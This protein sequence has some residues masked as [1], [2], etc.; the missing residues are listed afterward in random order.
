MTV[1]SSRR[2]MPLTPA[3][4]ER[5][6]P[7]AS[8]RNTR[9]TWQRRRQLPLLAVGVVLVA[10][11]ALLFALV[12]NRGPAGT[13]VLVASR[14]LPAGHVLSAADLSTASLRGPGVASI[15]AAGEA[16]LL[17]RPLVMPVAAG[18]L[19]LPADVG[20][21]NG[22][23]AG[24]AVVALALKPGQYPPMVGAGDRVQILNTAT[25]AAS[26][27]NG[28][29][30][31]GGPVGQTV[32]AIVLA[33]DPQPEG[34]AVAVV[35]SVQVAAGQAPAVAAMGAAGTGSLVLLAPEA[36]GP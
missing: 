25:A 10:G 29:A 16:G 13:Q 27:P 36:S 28:A 32:P 26:G 20:S 1:T 21:A 33:V 31:A 2:S 15:P 35:A 30:A 23:A 24:S 8:G 7:V 34:S 5:G 17:G 14:P 22:L 6:R 4:S 19:L 9:L 3:G 18:A 11:C 12:A